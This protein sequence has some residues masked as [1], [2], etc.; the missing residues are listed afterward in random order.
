MYPANACRGKEVIS[1]GP[2]LGTIEVKPL[3]TA[4]KMESFNDII[5]L[6]NEADVIEFLNSKNIFDPNIFNASSILW[7]LKN[8][9]VFE[10]IIAVLRS[11]CYFS[12]E[13]WQYS[14]YHK[15]L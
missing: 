12:E 14:I 7:M 13:I 15:D 2:S 4:V 8:K 3:S 5:R 9:T 11:R 10:K 6:G 1:K